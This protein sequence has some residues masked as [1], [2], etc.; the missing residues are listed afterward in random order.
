MWNKL[1]KGARSQAHAPPPVTET[2]KKNRNMTRNIINKYSA[3]VWRVSQS[4]GFDFM[5]KQKEILII[6]K[7]IAKM[8]SYLLEYCS[9]SIYSC[10][11][12]KSRFRS[13]SLCRPIIDRDRDHRG[14]EQSWVESVVGEVAVGEGSEVVREAWER[15]CGKHNKWEEKSLWAMPKST[16]NFKWLKV[17]F[18]AHE[19]SMPLP[20]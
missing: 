19:G 7:F 10:G 14:V 12:R 8:V 15:V 4:A 11:V 6:W 1:L 2:S 16:L 17:P 3:D 5:N 20:D 18:F 13:C 9:K